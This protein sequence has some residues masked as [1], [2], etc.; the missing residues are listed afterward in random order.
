M[1]LREAHVNTSIRHPWEVARA[2]FFGQQ[3]RDRGV[4]GQLRSGLDIG[5]G[6]AWFA[7]QLVSQLPEKARLHCVD[8]AYTQTSMAA[9]QA[10]LPPQIALYP[11]PPPGRHDLVLL[12][13]VLEHVQDDRTFLREIVQQRM[14]AGGRI[15]IS[16]PAW[17]GLFISH[18]TFLHH[19]RRYSPQQARALIEGAGLRIEASGGLFHSL[20]L[21]RLAMRVV[22]QVSGA[23]L[24]SRE[25]G[26]AWNAGPLATS[27]VAAALSIDNAASSW[28][29]QR[30]VDAPGLTWWALCRT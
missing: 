22:E 14:E 23:Q 12:L 21:P 11:T 24:H 13:D 5:A 10:K 28:L 6:D 3:L 2:R 9:L 19:F 26:I 17:Q 8:A 27:A 25:P 4:L 30:G 1:D 20:L 18:D 7:G 29:A 16:V 15:L